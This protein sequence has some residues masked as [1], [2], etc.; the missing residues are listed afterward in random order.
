MEQG[1]STIIAISMLAGGL[2]IALSAMFGALGQ[3]K[4]VAAAL[5]AI[6]RNPEAQS[7]IQM[8]MIIGL[9]FI[10]S[11]SLYALFI[12]IMLVVANPFVSPFVKQVFGG[13]H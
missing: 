1:I 12:A 2:T 9:A 5:E 10:E 6:G 4:A 3:G 8:A 11:L 13:G 7:K